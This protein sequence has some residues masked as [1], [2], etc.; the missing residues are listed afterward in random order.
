[1]AGRKKKK[2][3]KAKPPTID[4]LR[5]LARRELA[6]LGV[7]VR[8][9]MRGHAEYLE[10]KKRKPQPFPLCLEACTPSAVSFLAT[11]NKGRA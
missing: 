1:M 2:G 7:Q 9:P 11:L 5:P 3:R 4:E 8:D 10:R 6:T